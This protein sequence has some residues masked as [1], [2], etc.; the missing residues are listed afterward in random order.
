[1]MTDGSSDD[2][3]MSAE[4]LQREIER[5]RERNRELEEAEKLHLTAVE[6]LRQSEL[7]HAVLLSSIPTPAVA[8]G[9]NLEFLYCNEAYEEFVGKSL[10]DISGK[11]MEVCF[12]EFVDS[13]PYRVYRHTLE[14]GRTAEVEGWFG[15]RYWNS[16]VYP[17]PWGLLILSDDKTE[18]KRAEEELERS[19]VALRRAFEGTVEALASAF[20]KRDPYTAGHQRNVAALAVAIAEEMDLGSDRVDGIRVAGLLHD[21]GKIN[22]P[23]EILTKPTGLTELEYS[24]IRTHPRIGYDILRTV[25]FPW[26]VAN[27][28]LQHHENLDGSGYP[29]GLQGIA[30]LTEARILRVADVVETMSSHR[31][32]RAAIGT[33]VA[34]KEIETNKGKL[35][36]ETAVDVCLDLFASLRFQFRREP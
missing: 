6:E 12:P 29:Q 22:M 20:E 4:E 2:A 11:P 5:L 26:P 10:D 17:A 25:N 9:R 30:I 27:I 24:L 14:T 28:V 31:P 16:K 35:Y 36:D 18:E 23:A 8:L 13:T 1:M 33:A 19:I 15:E 21:I 7:R 34:L 3:A 32:Y